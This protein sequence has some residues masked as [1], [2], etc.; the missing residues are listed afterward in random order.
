MNGWR[1]TEAPQ[2]GEM[3]SIVCAIL[4]SVALGR[5]DGSHYKMERVLIGT[6]P[7]AASRGRRVPLEMG[8]LEG[9]TG[10]C[11]FFPQPANSHSTLILFQRNCILMKVVYIQKD[12]S[13]HTKRSAHTYQSDP[14]QTACRCL[15]ITSRQTLSS[16]GAGD[17]DQT[18]HQ[19]R[20]ILY[21]CV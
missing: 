18:E 8:Q 14:I 16:F 13:R 19:R 17:R 3:A 20:G 21:T 5:F 7:A 9:D 2:Y 6:A 4:Y 1:L 11:P 12:T 10:S 15:L